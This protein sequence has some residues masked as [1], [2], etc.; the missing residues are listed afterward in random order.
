MSAI[1]YVIDPNGDIYSEDKK[2][3][4]TILKGEAAYVFLKSKQGKN[5]YFIKTSNEDEMSISMEIPRDMVAVF[6]SEKNHS[7]Y[8]KLHEYQYQTLSLDVPISEEDD[9][10]LVSQIADPDEDVFAK[11]ARKET[12]ESVRKALKVLTEKE[13][14]VIVTMYLGEEDLSEREVSLILNFPQ[15]TV[16]NVKTRALKKLSTFLEK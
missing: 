6:R 10:P 5:R 15:K 7:D 4:Y 8:L 11:V 16:H 12:I 2:V 14:L 13:L 3:R 1:Y 9:E